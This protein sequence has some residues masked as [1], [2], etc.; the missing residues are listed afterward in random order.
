MFTNVNNIPVIGFI[1][2][3][4]SGKTT[5]IE[6]VIQYLVA[7]AVKVG[8]IKHDAHRFDIDKP[9]KDSWR[10]REAGSQTTIISS[11]T[12]IALQRRINHPASL[13]NLLAYFHEEELVIVEGHK[14]APHPKIEVY[15]S[16]NGKPLQYQN[17]QGV[18]AIA[19]PRH[20]HHQ[21]LSSKLPLL[22]LDD[23]RA[24]VDFIY[25]YLR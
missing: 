1:G 7:E 20:D 15:R 13:D 11:D 23:C 17:F 6:K 21:L 24:I 18:I 25:K 5:I 10:F 8:V 4:G 14:S 9:G 2:S 22:D 3:S 19:A 16:K 12:M